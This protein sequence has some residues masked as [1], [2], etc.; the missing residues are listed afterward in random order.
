M[1]KLVENG[2]GTMTKSLSK[3]VG[4]MFECA[5]DPEAPTWVYGCHCD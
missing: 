1:V 3:D 5:S 4:V 2:D